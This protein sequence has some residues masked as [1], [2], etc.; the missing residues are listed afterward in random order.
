[1][2]EPRRATRY[3]E[4]FEAEALSLLDSTDD[5]ISAV[6]DVPPDSTSEG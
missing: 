5:R 2:R 6:A 3:T 1:M 4:E